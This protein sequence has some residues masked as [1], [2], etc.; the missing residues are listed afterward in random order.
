LG[1]SPIS[2]RIVASATFAASFVF[3]AD[4]AGWLLR[5][6]GAARSLRVLSVVTALG[7]SIAVGLGLGI[8]MALLVRLAR[9]S[10]PAAAWSAR[11]L[12]KAGGAIAGLAAGLVAAAIP[13]VVAVPVRSVLLVGPAWRVALVDFAAIAIAFGAFAFASGATARRWP[14]PIPWRALGV[15]SF[16]LAIGAAISGVVFRP[17]LAPMGLLDLVDV[18]MLAGAALASFVFWPTG[19][20][21]R[22]AIG[23]ASTFAV[24]ALALAQWS[25]S[26]RAAPTVET[27][28]G[29]W[30][31]VDAARR[32][33]LD[34]DGF[35]PLFGGGDCNDFDS[36]VNPEAVPVP[37][38]GIDE[39]CSG[40]DRVA[41]LPWPKRPAFVPLPSNVPPPRSI[42]LVTIDSLRADRLGLYG[43]S[44]RTSPNIDAFARTGVVFRR[45]YSAGP[46]TWIAMPTLVTGRYQPEIRWNKALFPW[47]LSHDHT[48]IGEIMTRAGYTTAAFITAWM[49][50]PEWGY[51]QGFE[52]IDTE[53][54]D[55]WGNGQ[56]YRSITSPQIVD[57]TLAWLESHKGD[58]FFAWMHL[59]DPHVNFQPHPDVPSFG[60]GDPGLYD[61]EVFYTDRALGTFFRRLT[62]L[63]LDRTTAVVLMADHGE[64]LGE[65][66]LT[67]HNRVV[68]EEASHIP[69][70]VRVP[71]IAPREVRAVT[72]HID[73]PETLLNLA[74]IDAT[75]YRMSGATLVPDLLG[76]SDPD[77]EVV[78]EV[79]YKGIQRALITKRWK[80]MENTETGTYA[81]YD[82]PRDPGELH[83][84]ATREPDIVR[85]MRERLQAWK[86][87]VAGREVLETIDEMTVKAVPRHADRLAA[88][89]S[90]GIELVA[91]DFDDR[92]VDTADPTL[93]VKTYWRVRRRVTQDCAYR[94]GFLQHGRVA[95]MKGS[96]QLR[97]AM[98]IVPFRY[99]PIGKILEEV[100]VVRRRRSHGRLDGLLSLICDGERLKARGP[101]VDRERWIPL[102][103]IV[104]S[105]AGA[106]PALRPAKVPR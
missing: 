19:P 106:R 53:Y 70:V 5:T 58:R 39:S 105:N 8:G 9:A 89:F 33:D 14:R 57:K 17:R 72:S 46:A 63:G 34:R 85:S 35:S 62:E 24:V 91:A 47:G 84:L 74:G 42:I 82:I 7:A 60:P 68:W 96:G 26:A 37:G 6:P 50:L 99:F 101:H 92:R 103:S 15:V 29:R 67:L 4:L 83:D 31:V 28:P 20:R 98:G 48:T 25:E 65:H 64:M 94:L 55:G 16:V 41:R 40:H 27:R 102:G 79:R 23:A 104:V 38:N 93:P 32:V 36:W 45:A 11:P 21:V 49:F 30:A 12:A 86:E 52:H 73:I 97:P 54:A 18:A 56:V 2:R 88:R 90:N 10:G 59:F 51:T 78:S 80:L 1:A 100:V 77:R 76:H 75:P 69:L 71:G 44:K 95:D 87:Y 43:Y 66:G 3:L 81:L 61:G 13:V 22:L